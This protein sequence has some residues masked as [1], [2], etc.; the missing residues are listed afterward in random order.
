[1]TA[2]RYSGAVALVASFV[3][4]ASGCAGTA[5]VGPDG[6]DK[7]AELQGE[8]TQLENEAARVADASAIKKLQRAYGY[9]HDQ[10]MWDS[11]ADLFAQEGTI[12]VSLDGVYHRNACA[13]I[14]RAGR[15]QR[16]LA[17]RAAQRSPQPAARHQCVGRQSHGQGPLAPCP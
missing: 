17:A 4:L 10:K 13:S 12:E 2:H 16:G 9:Y 7:V 6:G 1:M 8:L 15:R 11:M 3:L 5:A 14:Q